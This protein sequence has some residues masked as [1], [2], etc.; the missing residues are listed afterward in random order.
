M[1]ITPPRTSREAK[2]SSRVILSF[3]TVILLLGVPIWWITTSIYRAK[4]PTELMLREADDLW[5]PID[6]CLQS[7]SVPPEQLDRITSLVS[8][9]ARGPWGIFKFNIESAHQCQFNS[10]SFTLEIVQGDSPSAG[11]DSNS[12]NARV[13]YVERDVEAVAS[14]IS[15][16]LLN[17]YSEEFASIAYLLFN[18]GTRSDGLQG[19]IQS[20]DMTMTDKIAKASTKSFK[21]NSGYHLTFSLFTAT[22]NPSSWSIEDVLERYIQPIL[23]VMSHSTNI[24][25]TSQ[26]Q[27]Y[28]SFSPSVHPQSANGTWTL[29]HSDLTS[30]INTAEWPLS[31][32]IG[33]GPTINFIAYV[34]HQKYIP[35]FIADY[36]TNSWLIPQYGAITI[37]NPPLVDQPESELGLQN[38]PAHLDADS[39]SPAFESFQRQLLQL[40]GV[41]GGSETPLTHRLQSFKR[42]RGLSLYLRTLSSLGSLARLEQ[43]LSNIP[44]PKRVLIHVENALEGLTTFREKANFRALNDA[45]RS[46]EKAFFDKSMVGQVYF[47]DEHKV[48]VYLPLLGPVGVPLI[49]G[50][51]REIK[52]FRAKAG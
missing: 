21:A 39:L 50:L 37:L 26:V 6:V 4:L 8:E 45:F 16:A 42:L 40:L 29:Q 49:I 51:L 30:F 24:S 7:A 27:L 46:A 11:F 28:S 31:P 22:A 23:R 9:K 47:P 1:R 33:E 48:A 43:H 34:P 2:L 17:F 32:S 12:G 19:Y 52:Q 20:L 44:I 18:H 10:S 14:Q 15:E 36:P 41:P 5:Y 13:V 38:L 35:L 25:V 3:W